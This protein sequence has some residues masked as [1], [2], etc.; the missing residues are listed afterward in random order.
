[1]FVFSEKTQQTVSFTGG[2]HVSVAA[3][4]ETTL[5]L[6]WSRNLNIM[7]AATGSRWSSTSSWVTCDSLGR[8]KTRCAAAFWIIW[9]M[10]LYSGFHTNWKHHFGFKMLRRSSDEHVSVFSDHKIHKIPLMLYLNIYM[11]WELNN[12]QSHAACCIWYMDKVALKLKLF[13]RHLQLKTYEKP[14]L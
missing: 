13:W 2:G 1:M 14:Q 6:A 4:P 5:Q 11:G 8:L 7:W 10:K 9:I 3:E 12:Y